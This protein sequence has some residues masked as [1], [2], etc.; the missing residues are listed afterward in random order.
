MEQFD[1]GL[2]V[3]AFISHDL[4]ERRVRNFHFDR[5]AVQYKKGDCVH[6]HHGMT[7]TE[8]MLPGENFV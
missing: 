7:V 5:R 3:T 8:A 1:V 4:L 2:A 6:Y